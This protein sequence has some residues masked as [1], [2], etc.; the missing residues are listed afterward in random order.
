MSQASDL[1]VWA[2]I[3]TS[4][5]VLLGACFTVTGAIGL[6]RLKTFYERIHAPTLGATWGAAGVLLGSMIYF[7]VLQ[8][9]P[10]LHEALIAIFLTVTTPVTLM[11][12]G[13]AALYRDNTEGSRLAR[14][15]AAR[16]RINDA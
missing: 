15:K 1:P 4:F 7:T 13:R 3:L 5:L 10:V 8:E 9:R 2:A 11:L 6:L 16:E 12:L 14:T